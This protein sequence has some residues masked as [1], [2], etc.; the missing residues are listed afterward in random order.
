MSEI[1]VTTTEKYR[2]LHSGVKG[3]EGV[4]EFVKTKPPR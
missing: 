3:F 2:I 1:H 4:D